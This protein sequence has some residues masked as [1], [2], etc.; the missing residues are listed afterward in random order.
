VFMNDS[1]GKIPTER[2]KILAVFVHYSQTGLFFQSVLER[3]KLLIYMK[4]HGENVE[5]ENYCAWVAM[6]QLPTNRYSSCKYPS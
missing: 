3:G 5:G 1:D 4:A 2:Y 6:A